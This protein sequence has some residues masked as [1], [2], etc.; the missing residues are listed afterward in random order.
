MKIFLIFFPFFLFSQVPFAARMNGGKIHYREG[1]YERAKEQF[2]LALKERPNSEEAHLWLGLALF[3]LG[4]ASTAAVHFLEAIK[5]DTTLINQI[6]KEE[7]KRLAVWSALSQKTQ[8][9]ILE[10]DYE[11][12]LPYAEMSI[13]IDETHPLGYTLLAQ[14]YS[15]LN[16]LQE[17]HNLGKRLVKGDSLSPQGYNILGIYFFAINS[18]DSAAITYQ[19][20]SNLYEKKIAEYRED[21][22]KEIKRADA[23][24]VIE[25][26]ISYQ[27]G[28]EVDKFRS[29]VEDSLRLKPKLSTI[30]RLTLELYNIVLEKNFVD[31]RIGSSYLQ[32]SS[33]LPESMKW[34]YLLKAESAFTAVLVN[35]PQ[36]LDAK[37]N[38]GFVKY[39]LGKEKVEEA[40]ILFKELVENGVYLTQ[41]PEKV[42]EEIS[43][44][45]KTEAG[46][47][48]IPLPSE[49]ASQIKEGNFAYLYLFDTLSP[50]LSP[51]EPKTMENLYLL[52]G[53]SY[54][55]VADLRKLKENYDKAISAFQKVITINPENVDAYQN[56]V[57]AYREKGDK[58]MAEKMY[59]KMEEIKKKRGSK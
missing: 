42:K 54:V 16:K 45:L 15:Q 30:A 6:R 3:Q 26:L 56:L 29:Y 58:K 48:A 21:L 39:S 17:L 11:N 5:I 20:A 49:I 19:R 31:F 38:L 50:F 4:D 35:N 57:V 59:L 23:E 7:D 27:K 55:R 43:S 41:L 53:A 1:R 44:L 36:D 28:K 13:R 51:F 10:N 32:K 40:V 18:W 47:I 34:G 37:Y 8:R 9:L 12:A 2:E 33:A 22:K 14:V 25:K 46:K 52:L 24:T